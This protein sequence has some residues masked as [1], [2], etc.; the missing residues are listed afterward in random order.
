MLKPDFWS[1]RGWYMPLI[2]VIDTCV[3]FS[4]PLRDTI[5]HAAAKQVF[6][7]RLTDDILDEFERNLHRYLMKRGREEEGARESV[8]HLLAMIRRAFAGSIITN[9][10]ELIDTMPVNAKDRHVMAAAVA[11]S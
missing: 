3:I 10:K 4:A 7:I 8:Q 6:T 11:S 1:R 2:A 5:F 9:H